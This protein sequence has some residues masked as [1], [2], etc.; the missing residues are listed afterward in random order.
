MKYINIVV[1]NKTNKIDTYFSY[2]TREDDV[3]V[4][5]KV[6]VPFGIKNAVKEG[7]VFEV[8]DT[9]EYDPGKV[10]DVISIVK[11]ESVTEEI[12][13][14]VLWMKGRY[15]IRLYDGVKCFTQPGKPP[16]EGKAKEPYKNAAGDYFPPTALTE[17]QQ[18]AVNAIDDSL[19]SSKQANFLIHGVTASGKTQV[20]MEIIDRCL[21]YGKTAIMLVPEISLTHQTIERFIGRFGKGRIAVLHSKLTKRERYDE[22]QRIKTGQAGIVIGARMAVFAPVSNLG[23]VILDEEHEATYKS[24]QNPKYDTVE[25]AL[26]RLQQYSGVLVLGSATPSVA[27]YQRC[28]EGIYRLLTLKERYNK[29]PLPEIE[30]IDMREELK[31]GNRSIFSYRLQ[32]KM[33]ETLDGGKQIIL[34]QNRRGYSNFILCRECGKVI[35]CDDCNIS[36]V[37]H[38]EKNYL[39]C[40]YCGK[41]IPAPKECPTCGS[42][43]IRHFGIGTEQVQEEVSRMFEDV[44]TERLDLDSVKSTRDLERILKKFSK[45]EIKI[46]VGTQMVAKGLD[47][48]NVGLVGVISAD[49]S[50]NIPDYR[51]EERTFQLITQ[52]AGR[53]GRG[54]ERGTVIVQSF[55]PENY[56]YKRAAGNDYEGFFSDEI[57][58]RKFLK[59]PP[60]G[61]IIMVNFTAETDKICNIYALKCKEYMVKALGDEIAG[62]ILSPRISQTFKGKESVRYYLI[63]KSDRGM[64]N[65]YVF[66][67]DAFR[68]TM[69]ENNAKCSLNIDVNPYSII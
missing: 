51:S 45:G 27:S 34:F 49:T 11:E 38:K 4:G 22:W 41:K 58:A 15:G 59:Y 44:T 47:F 48:A 24:D 42:R 65:K 67:L 19:K 16:K 2:K 33:K 32:E 69:D 8:S 55:E 10:K 28:R 37:Y 3:R 1:E 36:M 61:D 66:Y 5:D 46:L 52:V 9:S 50:L 56:A 63:I 54:E 23:T 62:K 30:L 29:T 13:K 20:Y 60:F 64:R 31:R 35:K 43:F 18:N 17:E 68:K 6:L 7:F 14:T 53:A 21:S 57:V 39:A 12:I 26:K 25:V 40:H